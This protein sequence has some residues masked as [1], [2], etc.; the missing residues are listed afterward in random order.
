MTEDE[1]K[2]IMNAMID[3][4]YSKILDKIANPPYPD[5]SEALQEFVQELEND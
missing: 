5:F 2:V 1:A 3:Y 4:W